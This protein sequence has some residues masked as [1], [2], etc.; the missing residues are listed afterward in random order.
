MLTVRASDADNTHMRIFAQLARR[1]MREEFRTSLAA[2]TSVDELMSYISQE[3][4]L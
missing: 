3:L 1:I 2:C 4:E